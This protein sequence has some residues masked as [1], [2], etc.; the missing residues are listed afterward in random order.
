V[1]FAVSY[2]G[3]QRTVTPS[4]RA[5]D[6]APLAPEGQPLRAAVYRPLRAGWIAAGITGDGRL[7]MRAQEQ[8]RALLGPARHRETAV[9]L[10][11]DMEGHEPTAVTVDPSGQYVVV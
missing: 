6:P 11:A 8:S 1:R 5:L 7:F 4:L 10:T 3:G 9:E 2:G